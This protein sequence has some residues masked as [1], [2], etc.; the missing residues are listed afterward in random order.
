MNGPK[1]KESHQNQE[2]RDR[3]VHLPSLLFNIVVEVLA[4]TIEQEKEIKVI[5]IGKE[6]KCPSDSC[7]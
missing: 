5:Q 4:R 1:L 7:R 6:V 3:A 2:R